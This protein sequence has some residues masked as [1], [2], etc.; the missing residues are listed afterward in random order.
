MR[1]LG[2]SYAFLWKKCIEGNGCLKINSNAVS[3]KEFCKLRI[4]EGGK[5][6]ISGDVSIFVRCN[7]HICKDAELRIGDGTYINEDSKIACKH[8]IY[9]GEQCAISNDV[10]I[11]DS[12]FHIVLNGDNRDNKETGISIGNH[13][14]IGADVSILKNVK[15]GDNCIIGARTL[16]TRDVPCNCMAVGNPMRIIKENISWK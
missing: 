9:I 11:M 14:W 13:C 2:T 12:D 7:I 16:V 10:S 8:N 15:I 4:D 3:Y 5:L 1:D 6:V